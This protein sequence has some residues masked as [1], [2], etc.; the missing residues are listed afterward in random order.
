ME[1]ERTLFDAEETSGLG[2]IEILHPPG[3]FSIT[4]A[5]LI[6]LQTIFCHQD[7]LGGV[8]ID[9][10]P[11]TGCLS[12]AA[13]RIGSVTRIIGLEI[14][15]ANVDEARKNVLRN[16]LEGEVDILLSDSY[17]PVEA[18]DAAKLDDLEGKVDFILSNPDA[19]EGDDG[20]G[21]RREVLRGGRKFLARD[22]VV[23]LSVSSQYG[24][25]RIHGLCRDISGFDYEGVL[26]STE[27]VPF[28]LGRAYL[29]TC[30]HLYVQEESKGGLEYVFQDPEA[31]EERTLNAGSALAHFEQT[32]QSPLSKWQTHLFRFRGSS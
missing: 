14:S 31:Q 5:S 3:T 12:I 17:T 23:V 4:P 8:G 26:E 10:G 22:G 13:A 15:R 1:T 18:R 16:G 9:W 19:S 20:F 28:D 2:R 7:L 21:Y 29:L 27:W 24:L 25:R 6:S 30:L 11:G 32:G